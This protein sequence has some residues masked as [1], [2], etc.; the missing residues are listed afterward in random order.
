[1]NAKTGAH[2]PPASPGYTMRHDHSNIVCNDP[3]L[4]MCLFNN[5]V[6]LYFFTQTIARQAPL[7]MR[8]SRQKY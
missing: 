3:K 2:L 7:S 5:Q 4:K 8:F 1:M 6:H